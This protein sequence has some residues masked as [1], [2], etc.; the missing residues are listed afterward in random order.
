MLSWRYKIGGESKIWNQSV[1]QSINNTYLWS[2]N[3]SNYFEG[4]IT[5]ASGGENH[6][7]FTY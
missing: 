2:Q 6:Y 1:L 3:D 5:S 4:K 7:G